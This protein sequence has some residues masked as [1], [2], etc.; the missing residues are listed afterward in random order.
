MNYISNIK[1]VQWTGNNLKQICRQ[2]KL[3][4][5]IVQRY[6]G[7]KKESFCVLGLYP[8][9][10]SFE[11]A[12]ELI[13]SSGLYISTLEGYKKVKKGDYIVLTFFKEKLVLS[14]RVFE[15]LYKK[16]EV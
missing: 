16:E 2:L 11:G 8:N 1:A 13:K 6:D 15:A 10:I 14:K 7:D 4:P 9:T 12:K 5:M 3:F